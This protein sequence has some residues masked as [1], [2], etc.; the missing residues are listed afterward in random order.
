MTQKYQGKPYPRLGPRPKCARNLPLRNPGGRGGVDIVGLCR[1]LAMGEG[2][3]I[4][5]PLEE[6]TSTSFVLGSWPDCV[7]IWRLDLI[8]DTE[9]SASPGS[10]A[11]C[12]RFWS[13]TERR[14]GS[15][16]M[17][18]CCPRLYI[19]WSTVIPSIAKPA[20][21]PPRSGR[22]MHRP[23]TSGTE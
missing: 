18:D 12:L 11:E 16:G 10:E 15:G 5:L 14:G 2:S 21:S 3:G 8:L 7:N 1:P 19:S 23:G 17:G 6:P 13:D 9:S 22:E 4:M 20:A